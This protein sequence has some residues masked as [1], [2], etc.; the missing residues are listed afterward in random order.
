MTRVYQPVAGGAGSGLHAD[1]TDVSANQ[2]H[3]E[4][5]AINGAHHTGTLD[6]GQIPASIARD[7]ELHAQLHAA[8][9]AEG[10]ADE[11]IDGVSAPSTQAFSDAASVGADTTKA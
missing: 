7:S 3:S 8:A 5:H 2:H 4:D 6:D 9:H 11:I 10:G 1:L